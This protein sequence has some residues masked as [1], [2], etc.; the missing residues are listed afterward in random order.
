MHS[1]LIFN[2]ILALSLRD[3]YRGYMQTFPVYFN[4]AFYVANFMKSGG[5]LI[6]SCIGYGHL[7][8]L[9]LKYSTLINDII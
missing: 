6:H 9:T 7:L 2:I 8:K 3:S 1:F 5:K 4:I